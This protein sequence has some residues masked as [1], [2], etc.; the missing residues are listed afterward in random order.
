MEGKS[1]KT[2]EFDKIMNIISDFAGSEYGK[3]CIKTAQPFDSQLEIKLALDKLDD[4]M[5]LIGQVGNLYFGG[6]VDYTDYVIRASIGGILGISSLYDILHALKLAS[7]LKNISIEDNKAG[8][9]IKLITIDQNLLKDLD[10]AIVDRE[11]LSNNASPL[12]RSLNRK[13]IQKTEE[14]NEKLKSFVNSKANEKYLQDV[15]ITVREG[16]YV[17]PVKREYKGMISGIT[18]DVSSSGGTYFIEPQ[19]IVNINNEIREIEIQIDEEINRILKDFSNRIGRAKDELTYNFE[20]MT[21]LDILHAKAQYA[22]NH[23]HTKPIFTDDG[24]VDIRQMFHPLIDPEVVVKTDIEM[25]SDLKVLVITGPNTGGK[26][27]VLKTVGIISLL[28]QSGCFIP[29]LEGSKIPIYKNI[30]TDI[31]DEQSIEQSLSTF[32]SHMVNIVNIL[33]SKEENS[34]NLFDELGAGTDPTEGAALAMS[35]IDSLREKDVKVLATTHYAELKLYA[36]STDGVVNGSMEFDV[37]SLKPT[38]R[39]N[40]GLPGRSNAFE[41]SKK[42]GLE[43]EYIRKAEEYISENNLEFENVLAEIEKNKVYAETQKAEYESKLKEFEDRERK[44]KEEIEKLKEKA[45]KELDKA[46]EEAREIYQKA[47]RDYEE[48]IKDANKLVHSIDNNSAREIQETRTHIRK[49][50]DKLQSDNK[51]R[52]PKSNVSAEDVKIG[53]T[54]KII[55]IDKVGQVVDLPNENGDLIVQVGILKVNSNLKDIYLMDAK[56]QKERKKSSFRNTKA[57][58]IKTE[59]DLRGVDTEE[60]YDRVDKYLDDCVMS[61]LKEAT[62]V[63]GKGT[64]ALRKATHELLRNHPHVKSYRLGEVGEGDTGV[65][66]VTLK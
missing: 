37:G 44:N 19:S 6:L 51:K 8:E 29:A 10:K 43:D 47:K 9:L 62:I 66:V 55:S 52:L 38:Y 21:E 59:I 53:S 36:L 31:G 3:T 48:I 61:G 39:L 7:D 14:A 30:Y 35:I 34:L 15:L 63:H 58:D 26:T 25:D 60:L 24:S 42:L 1:L 33:S 32:S 13:K 28:A 16:R 12:L 46:N 23:G 65:T 27:V 49:N 45:R 4:M 22:I 64:G 11:N 2:L 56:P 50:I 40:I 20:L 5:K 57:M 41:I 17:V 18:H 54:V